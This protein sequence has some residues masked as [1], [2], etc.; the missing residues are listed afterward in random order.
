MK[1]E[2][3]FFWIKSV[4]LGFCLRQNIAYLLYVVKDNMLSEGIV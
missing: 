3:L 1:M 2:E 4:V